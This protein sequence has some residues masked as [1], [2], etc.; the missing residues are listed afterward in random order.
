MSGIAGS[1]LSHVLENLPQYTRADRTAWANFVDAINIRSGGLTFYG[2][3]ILAA[4]CSIGYVVWVKLPIRKVMDIAAPCVMI[5][6]GIGRIGCFLNGCCYGAECDP[7]E[8][9]WALRFP[10]Y[11][12]PYLNE[13]AGVNGE[14]LDHK[15]PGPL[16][17]GSAAVKAPA[18]LDTEESRLAAAEHSTPLHPSQLYS[19]ITALLIAALLV[20]YYT[21]PHVP[22]RVLALMVLIESPTRFIL[23]MLR[24]EPPFVG[25]GSDSLPSLPPMSFS[26]V[27]S[28]VL[29]GVGLVLWFS[30]RGPKQ[31]PGEPV[32]GPFAAPATA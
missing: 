15:V 2:G 12:N 20:A 9:P 17:L 8:V 27:M 6:L 29:F 16:R 22:G 18:A 3:L 32:G 30:F 7:H 5:G 23:E 11:S 10:Y 21:T 19:T 28:V 1:R 31:I 24:A 4:F 13:V 25:R 26:M 14:S